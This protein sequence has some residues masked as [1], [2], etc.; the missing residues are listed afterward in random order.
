MIIGA[1]LIFSI[2]SVFTNHEI[3]ETSGTVIESQIMNGA[4]AIALGYIEDAKRLAF[5]ETTI[6][7]AESLDPDILTEPANLGA[8]F[9]EQ[10]PM[11]DDVDDFEN[12]SDTISTEFMTY[13]VA[14]TIAYVDTNNMNVS[15]FNQTLYKRMIVDVTSPFLEDTVKLIHIFSLWDNE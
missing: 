11:F 1:V 3:L 13:N 2:L 10:Y 14:A 15:L 7:G 6:T 9:G 12:Y 8:E 5:D 4:T